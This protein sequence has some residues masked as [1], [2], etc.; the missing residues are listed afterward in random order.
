MR[1]EILTP[2]PSGFRFYHTHLVAGANLNAGQY[3]GEVGP[4]YIEPKNKP[5]GYDREEFVVLKEFEPYFMRGG[6]MASDFLSG[7]IIPE[8]QAMQEKAE[9][10]HPTRPKGYEVGYKVFTI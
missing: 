9:K 1:R 5:T 3:N 10:A 6:D 4:V 7:N 2:G 8:L